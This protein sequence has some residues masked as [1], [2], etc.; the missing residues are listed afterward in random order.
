LFVYVLKKFLLNYFEKMILMIELIKLSGSKKLASLLIFLV[1]LLCIAP[2]K[3]YEVT[4]DRGVALS[5]I[6]PPTRIVSLLPSFTETLCELS[7]CDALVGVD[8]DS[9][10]PL[11]TKTIRHLGG[12][13]T[14]NIEGVV[15]LKPD[16]VLMSKNPRTSER[17]EQLGLKV[18][19]LDSKNYA[20]IL[21]TLEKLDLIFNTHDAQRVWQSMNAQITKAAQSLPYKTRNLRIYFEVSTGPYAAGPK[22]FIGETLTKLGQGNIVPEGLGEFPKL[23][24]EFIVRSNPDLI[25]VADNNFSDL[26][27][28]PGWGGM[29]AVREKRICPLTKEQSDIVVRPG[30]R[31]GEAARILAQCISNLNNTS[32]ANLTSIVN[33]SVLSTI[34]T[35]GLL[36]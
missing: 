25:I 13:L 33:S 11:Q 3:A 14:P 29:A 5:F 10:Y 9:N 16:L 18:F 28:R 32:S 22:S 15:A 24:S 20:D 34:P 35:K 7:R 27:R 4:D 1:S 8:D 23:S 2:S 21:R 6:S 30:P 36:P 17:F 12:G 26:M 31:M 19:I